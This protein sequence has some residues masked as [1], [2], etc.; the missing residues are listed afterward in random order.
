MHG[1][2]GPVR[3]AVHWVGSVLWFAGVFFVGALFL[4]LFPGLS[5]RAAA[6]IGRDPLQSL[7]LGL[8]VLVCVPFVAVVLLITIVG[9]PL[10]LLAGAALPAAHV[11]GLDRRGALRRAARARGRASGAEPATTGWRL[12]ALLLALRGAGARASRARRR[13]PHRRSSRSSPASGRWS[14]RA[15]AD[16]HGAPAATGLIAMN[17]WPHLLAVLVGA[18]LTVQ[19]G[20][21]ST[22]RLAIGSPVIATIVNFAVGLAALLLVA[23]ASGARVVPGSTSAVPAWAWL[24]G[25]L[26]AAYVAAT[27]VLGP[28]LGAA[29][30]L[31]LTL[32]GQMVAALIVDQY[33]VIGFPQNAVTP[34]RLAGRGPAGRRRAADRPSLRRSGHGQDAVHD[35]RA[36]H[37]GAAVR[38]ARLRR[39]AARARRLRGFPRA[40]GRVH[41]RALPVREARARRVRELRARVRRRAGSPSSRSTRTTSRRTRRTAPTRCA[42]RRDRRATS[43]RTWWT[44]TSRWRRPT[45]PP[46]RPTSSCSMRAGG[47]S[48][49]GSSTTAGPADDRPVTGADLRTGR[50]RRARRAARGLRDQRPSIGCNIKWKPGAEPDYY[51]G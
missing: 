51:A 34:A 26:G 19:V 28:R 18:G 30:L 17:Y 47:S 48:I 29:A 42:R 22:V 39:P 13:R 25:L 12:L 11:P 4:I 40:A 8:A 16:A 49:A 31:A 41:L 46:A 3:E 36:R 50:R 7:G 43:S 27:T 37:A 14:G 2:R 9:I 5:S 21:N 20:M 6:T 44:R 38:P 33:G 32:A 1:D 10:A 15:G 35:A 24:G 45:A 23:V